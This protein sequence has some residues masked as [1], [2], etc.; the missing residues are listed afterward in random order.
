MAREWKNDPSIAKSPRDEDGKKQISYN[1][2]L[3][4]V[5]KNEEIKDWNDR[6]ERQKKLWGYCIYHL[7]SWFDYPIRKILDCG[8]GDGLFVEYLSNIG[9]DAIGIDI[10]DEYVKYAK[11]KNRLVFYGDICNLKYYNETF[12][13]TYSHQVLGLVKDREKAIKECIRVTK[14]N[15]FMV[16]LDGL[17]KEKHFQSINRK[18]LLDIIYGIPDIEVLEFDTYEKNNILIILR[19][20]K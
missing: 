19:R 14:V 2:Y 17:N 5:V 7:N 1:V 3:E 9:Y 10:N 6:F 8:A 12:D 15:G 18:Q 11:S 16:A 13:L 20:T 4:K